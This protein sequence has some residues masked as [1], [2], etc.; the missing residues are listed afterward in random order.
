MKKLM[1]YAAAAGLLFTA[2]Q[3]E[4]TPSADAT[5]S[6]VRSSPTLTSNVSPVPATFLKKVLVEEF[7]TVT[8]GNVPQASDAVSRIA[9]N[10]PGRVYT[11]GMHVSG[12]MNHMHANKMYNGLTPGT[13]SVPSCVVSR[14]RNNGTIFMN[15]NSISA[16]VN[17]TLQQS[18]SC[19]LA[20]QSSLSGNSATVNVHC[21]FSASYTG[22]YRVNVYL[23]EDAVMSSNPS[24]SQANAGNTDPNNAYYNMG[25]PINGYLHKNVLRRVTTSSFG[26]TINP[27]VMVP[28]GKEVQT[29]RFDLPARYYSQSNYNVIAFIT[30]ANSNEVINVQVG[31]L[32]TTKDWN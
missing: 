7:V 5:P 1:F 18:V 30:E 11:V 27:A 9:G 23:V 15:P 10:N 20:L 2:C 13:P 31:R 22:S 8:N 17:S 25:N 16:M 12:I 21:G 6:G 3:K 24:F 29:F 28:G 14:I 4:E 32:G 26:N 19:G